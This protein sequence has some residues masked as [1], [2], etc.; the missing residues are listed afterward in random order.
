MK[1]EKVLERLK[2]LEA[3]LKWLPPNT[4]V[5]S[6]DVI[7]AVPQLDGSPGIH[8]D[9]ASFVRIFC[10]KTVN[11]IKDWSDRHDILW[12]AVDGV[13]VYRLRERRPLLKSSET[14]VE[15]VK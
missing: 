6:T 14:L 13:N 11:L 1:V 8:L 2:T 5:L 4:T 15:T 10:G 12:L 7:R 9:D 3:G